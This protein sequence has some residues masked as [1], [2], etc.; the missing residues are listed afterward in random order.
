MKRLLSLVLLT[1]LLPGCAGDPPLPPPPPPPTIVNLLIETSTDL[2]ADVNGN[3]APVMLRIFELREQ[4]NF[5]SADFFAIF[6]DE[7]A[8][9]AAD[10]ARKQ[11]LLLQPGETKS[12]ML[13]PADDVQAIGLFAGFR[14]L[15]TAQWRTG[16]ELKAHQ[17]Q[18]LQIRLKNNQLTVEAAN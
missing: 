8:T 17:T 15:D 2:N 7:K 13:T 11:E 14:Q 16:L 3:G 1:A 9:L 10:L 4:S 18:N 12:L 6:N 5:N